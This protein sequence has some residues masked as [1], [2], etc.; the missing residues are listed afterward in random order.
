MLTRRRAERAATQ[1]QSSAPSS[2]FRITIVE[3]TSANEVQLCSGCTHRVSEL[4]HDDAAF[5]LKLEVDSRQSDD[6]LEETIEEIDATE[7]GLEDYSD[8]ENGFN[9]DGDASNS[10]SSQKRS[11][12][13]STKTAKRKAV[14]NLTVEEPTIAPQKAVFPES[15]YDVLEKRLIQLESDLANEL[16]NDRFKKL[17]KMGVMCEE[18]WA[19]L[20]CKDYGKSWDEHRNEA[21]SVLKHNLE[22]RR[23]GLQPFMKMHNKLDPDDL[24]QRSM[25]RDIHMLNPPVSI[26]MSRMAN[27]HD[28][29][30]GMSKRVFATCAA[31]H[32]LT[33][34]PMH[35]YSYI[36]EDPCFQIENELFEVE[37][38]LK[39]GQP[40]TPEYNKLMEHGR[41]L[42]ENWRLANEA[43]KRTKP[44]EAEPPGYDIRKCIVVGRNRKQP[45]DNGELLV[46]TAEE[47]EDIDITH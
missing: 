43:M 11:S 2:K 16:D 17:C 23:E 4:Q 6:A 26:A 31:I 46:G 9:K 10:R 41:R 42:R 44:A 8:V 15:E 12:K 1:Q 21:I 38:K 39:R 37:H 35:N 40:N 18:R 28:A 14:T 20:Y 29:L 33:V 5:A 34:A 7:N 47:L 27:P 45:R 36:E 30:R 3:T 13:R 22:I 19:K 24:L 25:R 32:T